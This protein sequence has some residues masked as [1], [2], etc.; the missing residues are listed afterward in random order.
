M[1]KKVHEYF[2]GNLCSSATA[3]AVEHTKC[4]KEAKNAN[5]KFN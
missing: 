5:F 1:L 4:H 2:Q 3:R